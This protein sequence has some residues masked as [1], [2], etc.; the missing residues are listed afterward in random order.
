MRTLEFVGDEQLNVSPTIRW[1]VAA[2]KFENHSELK[3]YSVQGLGW[4]A[5]HDLIRTDDEELNW[6]YFFFLL[7]SLLFLL[8]SEVNIRYTVYVTR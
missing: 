4:N 8:D 2:M 7:L 3:A 1:S 5:V 6:V